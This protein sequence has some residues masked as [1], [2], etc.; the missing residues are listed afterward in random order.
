MNMNLLE[1]SP[2]RF[3][4]TESRFLGNFLWICEFD[5]LKLGIRLS[6]SPEIQILSS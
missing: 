5:P 2:L 6:Q 3:Q 4:V 1:S